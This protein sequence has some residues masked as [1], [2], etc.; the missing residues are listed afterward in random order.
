[1]KARP[2][3]NVG[4]NPE[5]SHQASAAGVASAAAAAARQHMLVPAVAA[6]AGGPWGQTAKQQCV[7]RNPDVQ[8]KPSYCSNAAAVQLA[9]P[10][11]CNAW[12]L[13]LQLLGTNSCHCWLP[14]RQLL[15]RLRSHPCC[16]C[17][18]ATAAA[19][20]PCHYASCCCAGANHGCPML[21]MPCSSRCC[22]NSSAAE[23]AAV[24]RVRR[25]APIASARVCCRC[26]SSCCCRMC[27]SAHR[28]LRCR[29]AA[30]TRLIRSSAA[31]SA[32]P[33]T[34]LTCSTV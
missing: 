15:L 27:T 13:Q 22:C 5:P 20:A 16:W 1:M 19:T 24:A 29:S 26:C 18:A 32:P 8:H 6:A 23:A 21:L 31:L 7:Q 12:T 2:C 14:L 34:V 10:C 30:R 4:I 11:P 28:F 33:P 3:S 9:A 17:A 25:S